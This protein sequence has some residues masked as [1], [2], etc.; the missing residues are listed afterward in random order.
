MKKMLGIFLCV[1]LVSMCANLQP[2]LYPYEQYEPKRPTQ[3]EEAKHMAGKIVAVFGSV[4][5]AIGECAGYNPAKDDPRKPFN[6]LAT[7][8]HSFA[9]CI[10]TGTRALVSEAYMHEALVDYLC[11]DE[12]LRLM[13]VYAL[14][15]EE[16]LLR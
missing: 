8:V 13:R 10:A 1:P 2:G 5:Q 6:A 4:L 15:M 12:G 11:T 14:T 9:D 3:R 7:V 16:D